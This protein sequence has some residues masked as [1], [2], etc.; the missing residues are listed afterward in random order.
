MK[1]FWYGLLAGVFVG[2][3]F[4]SAGLGLAAQP[5]RLVVNG[6]EVKT[7]V[8][9]QV[10]NGRVLVPL[11]FIAE[12]LGAEVGWDDKTR[13]VIVRSTATV[14]QTTTNINMNEEQS[15][16]QTA[17][18]NETVTLGHV[19]VVVRSVSY[20]ESPITVET[21]VFEKRPG[22]KLAAVTLEVTTLKLPD[23]P[24]SRTYSPLSLIGRWILKNGKYR[25]GENMLLIG[26]SYLLP[27]ET[28]TRTIYFY[29]YE[30]E[31]L[32]GVELRD[33]GSNTPTAVV[34]FQ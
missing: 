5:I 11:R 1:K 34:V 31:Q 28:I 10:V 12:A 9:P 3:L 14:A 19:Q 33:L 8:P 18:L 15:S 20:Y 32:S 16:L 7:D 21:I 29:I 22:M 27:G 2:F 13:T 25:G 4:A 30:N 17:K 6:R 23:L 24:Y 26:T